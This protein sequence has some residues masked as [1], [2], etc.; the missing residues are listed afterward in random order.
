MGKT[1]DVSPYDS[2]RSHPSMNLGVKWDMCVLFVQTAAKCQD[3]KFVLAKCTVYCSIKMMQ[4]LAVTNPKN[5]KMDPHDVNPTYR[6]YIR[7]QETITSISC[8]LPVYSI[9]HN[10]RDGD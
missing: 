6:L 3:C 9:D 4:R 8:I 5:D 1:Y 7:I 2:Q 10:K